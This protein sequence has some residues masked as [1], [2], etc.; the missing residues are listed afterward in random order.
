[1]RFHE[2]C[3]NEW[4]KRFVNSLIKLET[5][6]DLFYSFDLPYYLQVVATAVLLQYEKSDLSCLL[7]KAAVDL[8]SRT[9]SEQQT[10]IKMQISTSVPFEEI[11]YMPPLIA[12]MAAN[13]YSKDFLTKLDFMEISSVP[14][15]YLD[16]N[17]SHIPDTLKEKYK[18]VCFMMHWKRTANQ[19]FPGPFLSYL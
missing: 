18:N 2:N 12:F 9:T 7:I 19:T 6:A 8:S 15:E 17:I 16:I 10:K 4:L 3:Q 11:I 5:I 13:E 14:Y 1:M